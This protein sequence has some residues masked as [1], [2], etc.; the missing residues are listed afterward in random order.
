M[1][2]YRWT[3]AQFED[4]S[5]HDNH[6]HALRIVEGAYGAGELV[7]DLD[8]ILEWLC[9]AEEYRF[10]IL[11]ATLTFLD[12]TRLRVCLDYASPSAALSP[13]SIHAIERRPEARERYVAQIWRIVIDWPQGEIEFEAAGFV[14]HGTEPPVLCRE[15]WLRPE[16]RQR[17]G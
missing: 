14:Q 4:M 7:L 1:P 5:W 10:R 6:V 17:H 2:D 8:Y 11:P 16:E 12:V 15:Q 3:E 9:D 13:F